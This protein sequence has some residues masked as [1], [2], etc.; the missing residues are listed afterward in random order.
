MH[1]RSLA[2]CAALLALAACADGESASPVSPNAD[3]KL[4]VAPVGPR[5]S[6]YNGQ[7][8]TEILDATPGWEVGSRF[9]SSRPGRIIGFRFWRASG[10]TGSNSVKLWTSSGTRL[11]QSTLPSGTGWVQSMLASPVRI[12]AN[13]TYRVSANTNARQVKTGGGYVY[14]GHLSSGPL[15]SDGGYYGQPTGAMPTT[16]SASYFF[17]DVIFEEDVPLPNL[18]VREYDVGIPE[19]AGVS[20]CN[21]GQA[22]APATTTRV[23]HTV[24]TTTG[25]LQSRTDRFYPTDALAAGGCGAQELPL[26]LGFINEYD[27]WADW[28][29]AVYESSEGDNRRIIRR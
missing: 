6:L 15:Y 7:A 11:A 12:A 4:A 13:T 18:Y 14:N 21:D 20:I 19:S 24:Y 5:W 1:A 22:G 8:P 17:V 29:D 25:A 23:T 3:A 26:S 16:E 10:E 27:V 28:G 2:A 9:R